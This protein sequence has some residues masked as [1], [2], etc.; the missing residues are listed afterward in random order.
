V[1]IKVNHTTSNHTATTGRESLTIRL[2]E[3]HFGCL[4]HRV[5]HWLHLVS[6]QS[7]QYTNSLS[8]LQLI[9][10]LS[11]FKKQIAVHTWNDII[12]ELPCLSVLH[13]CIAHEVAWKIVPK[14]MHAYK[15]KFYLMIN[16][17]CCLSRQ[18]TTSN[19]KGNCFE[20]KA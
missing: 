11:G 6:Q 3:T 5:L 12:S 8:L 20:K 4:C 18:M 17:I 7:L 2:C 9:H 15:Y 1:S 19:L 10:S 16:Q 14:L 13:D